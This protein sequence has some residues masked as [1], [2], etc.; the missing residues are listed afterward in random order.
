MQD[1]AHFAMNHSIYYG[2]Y[3][4]EKISKTVLTLALA[5][6]S[7]VIILIYSYANTNHYTANMDADI[8]AE[9]LFTKILYQ[10]H[11]IQPDTWFAS[12]A[13]RILSAP[14]LA[15]FIYPFAGFDLNTSQYCSSIDRLVLVC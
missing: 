5:V 15:S 7:V 12:T 1:N 13:N 6:I 2:N 11:H 14:M 10:N 9:T 8:A 3:T 4:M